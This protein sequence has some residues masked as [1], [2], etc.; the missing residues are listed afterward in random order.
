MLAHQIPCQKVYELEDCAKDPQW[1]ARETLTEWDD[2]H[3]PA[4]SRAS[5]S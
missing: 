2:P 5:A 3:V 4:T 1:Q